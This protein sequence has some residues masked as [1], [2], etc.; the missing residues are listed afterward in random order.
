MERLNNL[1]ENFIVV[2]PESEKYG[3]MNIINPL[4]HVKYMSKNDIMKN[5]FF[6]FDLKAIMHVKSNFNY[7]F[8]NSKEILNN[9]YGIKKHNAKLD[10][11]YDIYQ[12]LLKND[13]LKLNPLFKLIFKNKK[14]LVYRYHEQDRELKNA[15]NILEADYDFIKNDRLGYHHDYYSYKTISEEVSALFIKIMS[16]VNSGVDLNKIFIYDYPSEYDL[17]LKK[18][19]RYHNIHIEEKNKRVI[20]DLPVFKRFLGYLK[21]LSLKEAYDQISKDKDF[22]I[23]SVLNNDLNIINELSLNKDCLID[24]VISIA[25]N[26]YAKP[27]EYDKQ[28]RICRSA[29]SDDEYAFMLGFSIGAYPVIKKDIDFLTDEEKMILNHNTS[30]IENMINKDQLIDFISNTKNL[31]ISFKYKE[32][33]T[34]YYP[35]ILTKE[36]RMVEI[37]G[38]LEDVRYSFNCAHLEVAEHK[39]LNMMYGLK[40]PYMNSYSDDEIGFMKYNHSFKGLNGINDN[41]M[42]L[43]STKIE[44]YNNCPFKYFVKYVLNVNEYIP[45]FSARLG[46]LFHKILEDSVEKEINLLDYSDMI[47]ENFTTAK[48]RFFVRMLLPQVNNVIKK[49]QMMM[50]NSLFK[51]VLTEEKIIID[52]DDKTKLDGRIDKIIFDDEKKNLA[53]IDCKTYDLKFSKEYTKY[54]LNMQLPIYSLL[55]KNN[56]PDYE[57][58]GIFIQNVLTKEDKELDDLYQLNG[59]FVNDSEIIKRLD[60]ELGSISDDKM[61]TKSRF[62]AK[63]KLK[64]DGCLDARSGIDKKELD[65]LVDIADEQ[66]KIAIKRI[67]NNEFDIKPIKIDSNKN[68]AYCDFKDICFMT[69]DDINRVSVKDV[70]TDEI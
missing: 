46:T 65:G 68:C 10:L 21:D 40:S 31:V 49:N 2:C 56:F 50:S 18:Y 17:I 38:E 20:Y 42:K 35:S 26:K 14:V 63:A 44:D 29:V 6:D 54:G 62:I 33:K 52:I 47:N 5:A 22:D 41:S 67:R 12:S 27:V 34:I 53:V 25:K 15:L 13:L 9:L 51:R 7:S 64:K 58:I 43:S 57:N 30:A 48:E 32:G 1:K 60:Q 59:L 37:K 4:A 70:D 55:L 23:F 39:D 19:A 45:S 16:L 11:L 61:I 3:L 8:S 69:N 36:L 66:I 24:A 28:I